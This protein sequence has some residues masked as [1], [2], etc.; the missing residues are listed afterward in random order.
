MY[1]KIPSLSLSHTASGAGAIVCNNTGYK[2]IK[3]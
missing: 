2:Y 1:E 3:K